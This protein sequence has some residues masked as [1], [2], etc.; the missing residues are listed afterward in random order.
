MRGVGFFI[1]ASALACSAC[2]VPFPETAPQS[3]LLPGPS[4]KSAPAFRLEFPEAPAVDSGLEIAAAAHAVDGGV[5]AHGPADHIGVSESGIGRRRTIGPGVAEDEHRGVLGNH[6]LSAHS[7][8]HWTPV[9][10]SGSLLYALEVP[11]S[12]G[13]TTWINLAA[14]VNCKERMPGSGFVALT[15][16]TDASA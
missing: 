10:S 11:Q 12:G 15:M 9:P 8:H 1:L 3:D 14:A 6:E 13:D 4:I 16:G 5:P 7:D 2:A